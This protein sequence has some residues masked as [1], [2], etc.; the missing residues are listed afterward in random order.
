MSLS[1]RVGTLVLKLLEFLLDRLE[2]RD[3]S[4]AEGVAALEHA[5][6]HPD[7]LDSAALALHE[8]HQQPAELLFQENLLAG[9]L[10][11]DERHQGLVQFDLGARHN[12]TSLGFVGIPTDG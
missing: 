6:D 7:G 3:Q 5:V 9:E 2:A 8:V 12:V 4:G 10:F 11:L 1:L